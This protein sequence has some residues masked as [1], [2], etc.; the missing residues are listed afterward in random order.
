MPKTKDPRYEQF[1]KEFKAGLIGAES[2]GDYSAINQA[3]VKKYGANSSMVARG[4]YQMVPKYHWED[5]KNVAIK[6]KRPV[7]ATYDDYLKDTVLQE[8]HFDWYTENKI[9]PT[10]NRDSTKAVK[11]GLSLGAYGYYNHFDPSSAKKFIAT[12]EHRKATDLNP[13]GKKVISNFEMFR[14]KSGVKPYYGYTESDYEREYNNYTSQIKN[15]DSNDNYSEEI[16]AQ[17]KQELYN[18]YRNQGYIQPNNPDGTPNGF[19]MI[20]DKRNKAQQKKFEEINSDLNLLKKSLQ[21]REVKWQIKKDSNGVERQKM[22]PRS[23]VWS[24]NTSPITDEERKKLK[25]KYPDIFEKVRGVD[26]IND[27]KALRKFQNEYNQFVPEDKKVNLVDA[28]GYRKKD[29]SFDVFATDRLSAIS[30]KFNPDLPALGTIENINSLDQ[31]PID[32]NKI[33]VNYIDYIAPTEE[34]EKKVEN[35]SPE[36]TTPKVDTADA[37]AKEIESA[38]RM[39]MEKKEVPTT[40]ATDD[41]FRGKDEVPEPMSNEFKDNFPWAQVLGNAAGAFAGIAMADKKIPMRDEQV[42]DAFR[43][44]AAELKKLSEI[45]LRP[46]EEAYAKRMITESYT[47]SIDQLVKA[48]GGARNLVLGNLGRIDAQKNK[49]LIELAVADASAKTDALYKY[50]EAMQYINDFDARRDIA[51]NERKYKDVLMTKEAGAELAQAGFAGLIDSLNEYRDNKPGSINHLRRS[52][53]YMEHFGYDPQLKDDK[54]GTKKG[55]YSWM[56]KKYE[57]LAKIA[58]ERNEVADMYWKLDDEG[59]KQMNDFMLKNNFEN[60]KDF[61]KQ[62]YQRQVDSENGDGIVLTPEQLAVDS[63]GYDDPNYV[64]P[65]GKKATKTSYSSVLNEADNGIKVNDNGIITS[66]KVSPSYLGDPRYDQEMIKKY[67]PEKAYQDVLNKSKNGTLNGELPSEEEFTKDYI[68]QFEFAVD[69]KIRPA[70]TKALETNP[71]DGNVYTGAR[72]VLG[73]QENETPEQKLERLNREA[74][75]Y[76]KKDKSSNTLDLLINDTVKQTEELI[77][78]TQK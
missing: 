42:S 37:T 27:F 47:G 35:T 8:L 73:E 44:Y 55:T 41:F 63:S 64:G 72:V 56:L 62:I 34:E 49:S 67:P 65:D 10:V 26:V 22:I 6:N 12:G 48:S 50:G 68:K 4:K 29:L 46:E 18:K 54:T 52:K 51:N 36:E 11:A 2:G 19:N 66:E 7:P 57:N 70:E 3:A 16:K 40:L 69:S 9:W 53:F 5:I 45:G 31:I 59:K 20:I 28:I 25:E 33:K 58:T 75:E 71:I 13:S 76:L 78:S 74:E 14:N 39:N 24:P 15:I 17:M 1:V 21:G 23:L 61:A 43:N 30:R 77:K 38:K 32:Q 60:Y